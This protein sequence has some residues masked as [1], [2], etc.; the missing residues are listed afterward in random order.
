[1]PLYQ[2]ATAL[3]QK[4]VP[5]ANSGFLQQFLYEFLTLGAL[6]AGDIID[7]GPI[8]A[9]LAPAD[10]TLITDDLDTNGVPAI[11]MTVGILNAAKSDIGA[12]ANDPWIVASTVG[13][14]GG[15]ARATSAACYLSGP[16]AV[17]R[18]LGIKIVAAPATSAGAGKKIAVKVDF[19]P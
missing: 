16:A 11:T 6:A 2:S 1:M 3:G 5:A 18:R 7:L 17:E 8:Q 9:D 4:P 14:T 15:I 13:Q 12:G 10:C 19:Q